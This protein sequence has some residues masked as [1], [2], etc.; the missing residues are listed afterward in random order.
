MTFKVSNIYKSLVRHCV[1][2]VQSI[3]DNGVSVNVE[4]YAWDS[5]GDDAEMVAADLLGL[6]GWTFK[7]NGGLWEVYVG[8]TVSTINDENL[9]REAAIID[10]IHELWGEESVV[11]M[12][13]DDGDAYSMLV[14]K[15]FEMLPAGQS[16][17][18][19]YRPIGLSLKRTSSNA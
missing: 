14:V 7:E 19:N 8:L 1:D 10:A 3:R 17:K 18:R 4:Y 15:E 6:A 5:R 16:E 11:P 9:L 2:T 12:R 13:D